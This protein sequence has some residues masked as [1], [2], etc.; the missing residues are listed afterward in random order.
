MAGNAWDAR[1]Y[2]EK[3]GFV[4]AYGQGLLE[5]LAPQAGERILDLGCGTGQLTSQI[6]ETGARVVGLDSSPSMIERA[7]A[8]HPHL[9]FIVG[10]A[11]DFALPMRF[12]AVFSNAALHWVLE[13]EQV[14]AAIA[15]SLRP[16]GRLVAELG[17]R[18]N[19][20]AVVG[21]VQAVLQERGQAVAP[22]PWYFPALG[23]YASLLER[24]GLEVR[25]AALFDRPTRLE[26]GQ[27]GLRVWFQMFGA[28]L[29]G[30]LPAEEQTELVGRVEERLRPL[31]F[32]EGEW[33]A[34]YRRLRVVAYREA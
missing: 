5:V 8:A 19:I 12:D 18:G 7:Q 34:D 9:T 32:R 20:R 24:A 28:P 25:Q 11:R 4:A 15:R 10:D 16:G 21:A 23:E 2:D 31:L 1:L 30:H 14:A 33:Y 22:L 6:A 13:A 3:H 26:D 29:V 17:G 27:A